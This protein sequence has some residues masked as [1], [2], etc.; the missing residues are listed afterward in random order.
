MLTMNL[1]PGK[2]DLRFKWI[3]I[4]KHRCYLEIITADGSYAFNKWP[5]WKLLSRK[6]IFSPAGFALSRFFSY[7]TSL[8]YHSI[9]QSFLSWDKSVQLSRC[10]IYISC[11]TGQ[12]FH[13]FTAKL[14]PQFQAYSWCPNITTYF[15]MSVLLVVGDNTHVPW[16][17]T[18]PCCKE[19]RPFHHFLCVLLIRLQVGLGNSLA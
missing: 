7:P 1:A 19:V 15:L 5:W 14:F 6:R 13:M 18:F 17:M 10:L 8:V 2:F 11:T 12:L 3:F 16:K 4:L 9:L